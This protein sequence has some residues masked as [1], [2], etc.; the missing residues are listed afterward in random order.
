MPNKT[1]Y[2]EIAAD[3]EQIAKRK[4]QDKARRDA[5]L[6]PEYLALREWRR[7]NPV[8]HTKNLQIAANL[9][10]KEARRLHRLANPRTSIYTGMNEDERKTY[11]KV[12]NRQYALKEAGWTPESF[13]TAKE[14]QEGR[15]AICGK[16]PESIYS[17]STEGLV[18]DHKHDNPPSPRALLCAGCNSAIGSLK[19]SPEICEKAAA[20]LRYWSMPCSHCGKCFDCLRLE[21]LYQNT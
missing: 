6:S 4:A 20:Y 15:C 11:H 2:A 3:P 19:E 18:P 13:A 10:E 1:R 14:A 21:N 16:V 9:R 12:K 17:N 7:A 8:E 5:K